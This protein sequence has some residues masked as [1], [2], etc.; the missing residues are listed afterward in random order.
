MPPS[1]VLEFLGKCA[2]K[3][4]KKGPSWEA[5]DG[6]F[7]GKNGG[8]NNCLFPYSRHTFQRN[9]IKLEDFRQLIELL[10]SRGGGADPLPFANAPQTC[11][12]AYA[13]DKDSVLH[14]A[15]LHIAVYCQPC[16]KCSVALECLL[17]LLQTLGPS[18]AD[19]FGRNLIGDPTWQQLGEKTE[20]TIV[21]KKLISDALDGHKSLQKICQVNVAEYLS[22][23]LD[24]R[25]DELPIPKKLMNFPWDKQVPES[26][27]G[28]SVSTS[29]SVSPEHQVKSPGSESDTWDDKITEPEIKSF[30][31]AQNEQKANNNAENKSNNNAT[32][33]S[34]HIDNPWDEEFNVLSQTEADLEKMKQQ[35]RENKEALDEDNP[36]EVAA[37]IEVAGSETQNLEPVVDVEDSSDNSVSISETSD[38]ASTVNRDDI[39]LETGHD[40]TKEEIEYEDSDEDSK[41]QVKVNTTQKQI[42]EEEEEEG[43]KS[44]DTASIDWI[45]VEFLSHV[46]NTWISR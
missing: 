35:I 21:R 27:E 6:I 31:E 36:N 9:L 45:R 24:N 37:S 40:N 1:P 28:S 26:T 5:I 18:K 22:W 8:P 13:S 46:E 20:L 30:H 44:D 12:T 17:L 4:F 15:I 16:E 19:K 25:L 11:H 33:K 34:P 41:T 29:A 42:Q 38:S 39:T 7:F 14:Q 43:M 10:V 2:T 32:A 23:K 3:R